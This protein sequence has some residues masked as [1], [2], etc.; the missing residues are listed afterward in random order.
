MPLFKNKSNKKTDLKN[1]KKR[2]LKTPIA[3]HIYSAFT[4]IIV[5]FFLSFNINIGFNRI[6]QSHTESECKRRIESAIDSCQTFAT[7]F[8]ETIT[9]EDIPNPVN[10]RNE[11]IKLI[12]YTAD[13]STNADMAFFYEESDNEY[14]L[15]WPSYTFDEKNT[16]T[17]QKILDEL[18]DKNGIKISSFNIEKTRNILTQI[19]ED[20]GI[21][22]GKMKKIQ[23][24]N[25]T[26]Y[27][28]FKNFNYTI[29]EDVEFQYYILFFVDTTNYY[30][31]AN[32]LY[33]AMFNT[34]I[35]AIIIAGILS[36]IISFPIISS[37]RKLSKF[38]NRIS[39]GDFTPNTGIIAS[40]ELNDLSNTMN[41]MARKLE[42]TDKNQKTFFQNAS[43]ELRTPL[44]SIQGYAE[45]MKYDVIDKDEAVDVIIA[46]TSRLSG[47]V[48][49][50]LSISKMD[51]SSSKGYVVKKSI[52]D[53]YEIVG[54]TIEKVRGGFLHSGKELI[55][56]I[57]IKS[58]V[59]IYANENDIFRMLE[60]IF[61]NCL[62]YAKENVFFNC[63]TD[64]DN[65]YFE[66]SDDGPGISDEVKA[67]LFERFSKG[68]DGKHGIGLALVKAIA[69]EH[70]GTVVAGNKVEGGAVF[71]VSIPL[72][73][74][75]Q[76]LSQ[77]NKEN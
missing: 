43:H 46:E 29:S 10:R 48:E 55:N 63:Y 14:R 37:T 6:I 30:S 22:L 74:A 71:R 25:T 19:I 3:L 26:Y 36:I 69:E 28:M 33:S 53:V 52:V 58:N 59:H 12:A 35:I 18:K 45:G 20:K 66:I 17:T 57:S 67:H 4:V 65:V 1:K 39:K 24:E 31:Y 50:L 56:N 72:I 40:R 60:N 42:E 73:K 8:S 23:I 41:D 38:A 54:V 77:Q 51:L 27:Y 62:R 5:F 61:S 16:E 64:S 9:A 49:N 2:F 47:M 13:S 34:M 44:M 21:Q 68:S 75:D 7:S 70:E 15:I 76:Q 11:L 32:E